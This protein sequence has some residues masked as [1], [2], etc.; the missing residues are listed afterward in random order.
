M[1]KVDGATGNSIST[2]M[3]KIASRKYAERLATLE[4]DFMQSL[5]QATK[6][7]DANV[8]ATYALLIA[9][10]M[11]SAAMKVTKE[12]GV[13]DEAVIAAMRVK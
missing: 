8:A 2:I 6:M 9:T 13:P 10:R 7:T 4:K 11:G 1:K 3:D 5:E 12:L